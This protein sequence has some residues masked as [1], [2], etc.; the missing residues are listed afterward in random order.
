MFFDPVELGQASFG[1]APKGLN[2]VD[3]SPAL[4]K[5]LALVDANMTVIAHIDQPVIPPPTIG[6]EH[7]GRVDFASD[8]PLEGPRRTVGHDLGVDLSV[9][10]KNAEDRLFEGSSSALARTWT[11]PD[12]GR[13]EVGFISLDDANQTTRRHHSP[14]AKVPIQ[15][16]HLLEGKPIS[17]ICEADGIHPT[18]F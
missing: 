6:H 2:A 4:G 3:M 17:E 1:K 7:A 14:E 13:S 18:L 15:R 10:L 12:P 5:S 16:L 8:H 11:S 9:T